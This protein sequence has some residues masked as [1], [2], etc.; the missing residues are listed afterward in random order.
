MT[1]A[2]VSPSTTRTSS[3]SSSIG[4]A[5][6]SV[7][8]RWPSLRSPICT[9]SRPV[10]RPNETVTCFSP[11]GSIRIWNFDQPLPETWVVLSTVPFAT[12]IASVS[13][14]RSFESSG[15]PGLRYSTTVKFSLPVR[16][17]SGPSSVAETESSVTVP[18]AVARSASMLT[19]PRALLSVIVKVSSSDS[20][21]FVTQTVIRISVSVSPLAIS[22]RPVSPWKSRPSMAVP[23]A[24]VQ[25]TDMFVRAGCVSFT[26]K[27]I[28]RSL[29]FAIAS[30]MNTFV[31]P[32]TN[33]ASTGA[34]PRPAVS[35]SAA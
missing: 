11:S 27:R 8:S 25:P 4:P 35:E 26:L 12:S 29:S 19:G 6:T 33:A 2:S 24:V 31:G 32:H 22:A 5:T 17:V 20:V 34:T 13:D 30:S 18:V 16:A 28:A 23:L 14:E 21:S 7:R 9:G 15:S 3:K 1:A 10:E